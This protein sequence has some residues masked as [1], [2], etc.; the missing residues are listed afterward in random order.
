M[1]VVVTVA[2]E[3]VITED[4]S[5]EARLRI[6]GETVVCA[7]HFLDQASRGDEPRLHFVEPG[8]WFV[9]AKPLLGVD[10]TF[11]AFEIAQR[12]LSSDRKLEPSLRGQFRT[13]RRRLERHLPTLTHFHRLLS[14]PSTIAS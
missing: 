11:V 3:H 1:T 5:H 7:Q 10:A 6:D 14:F 9:F 8:H 13:D 4:G 2:R 12:D